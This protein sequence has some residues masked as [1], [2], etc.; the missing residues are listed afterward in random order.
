MINYN[1]T[2]LIS[3]VGTYLNDFIKVFYKTKFIVVRIIKLNFF[4]W[5]ITKINK[6][7]VIHLNLL[8]SVYFSNLTNFQIQIHD[9]ILVM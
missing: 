9:M 1:T 4:I 6:K 3:Y 8:L 7:N 5:Q 2:K